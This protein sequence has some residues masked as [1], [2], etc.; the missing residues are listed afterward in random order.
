[1]IAEVEE[2]WSAIAETDDWSPLAA[3]IARLRETR[4]F[5]TALGLLQ[6]PNRRPGHVPLG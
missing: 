4:G 3:K 6:G 5:N 2:I 1:V